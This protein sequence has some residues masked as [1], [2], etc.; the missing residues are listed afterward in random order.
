VEIPAEEKGMIKYSCKEMGL[1][2]FFV[3][4]G[5]T[6]E[7]V[8]RMALEHVR[9]KHVDDFNLINTPAEIEQMEKALTRSLRVVAG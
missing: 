4:K 9:E 5:E 2:C 3:A 1:N 8:T 7:E 6:L